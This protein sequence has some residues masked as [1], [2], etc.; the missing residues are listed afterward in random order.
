MKY[1]KIKLGVV[2]QEPIYLSPPSWDCGWY[3]GWGYLGNNN[4]HY[5][6]S[7]LDK[8]KDLKTA[9][10]DH[11][12][13]S[14]L[15]E[16]SQRWRFAELVQSFYKLKDI[17]EV[18]NIGGSRLCENPLSESIKNENE[19]KRINEIL[20]PAIFEKAYEILNNNLE[21]E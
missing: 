10:D 9:I 13:D 7:G 18:Y 11:F 5:H 1:K 21:K 14:Y 4:C 2:E 19:V 8:S 20:L 12:G 3:W 17:A 16:P 15:I 6:L